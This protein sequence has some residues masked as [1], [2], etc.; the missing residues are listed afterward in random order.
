V[1]RDVQAWWVAVGCCLDWYPS[2]VVFYAIFACGL[3]LRL[4]LLPSRFAFG[5]YGKEDLRH[6]LTALHIHS[7]VR[8]IVSN[9]MTTAADLM[10]QVHSRFAPGNAGKEDFRPLISALKGLGFKL[11]QHNCLTTMCLPLLLLPL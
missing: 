11:V 7:T 5:T 2:D 8:S 10:A 3:P 9:V 6:L 1:A 4:L